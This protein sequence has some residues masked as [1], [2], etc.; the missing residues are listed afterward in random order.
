MLLTKLTRYVRTQSGN[1]RITVAFLVHM[2]QIA[3]Q[4]LVLRLFVKIVSLSFRSFLSLQLA[5]QWK[6]MLN[7]SF[8]QHMDAIKSCSTKQQCAIKVYLRNILHLYVFLDFLASICTSLLRFSTFHLVAQM[9]LFMLN[10]ITNSGE[11]HELY[12]ARVFTYLFSEFTINGKS[13]NVTTNNPVDT[14]KNVCKLF[15]YSLV[16]TPRPQ[17]QPFKLAT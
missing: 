5:G 1:A 8:T 16:Y 10:Q 9:R 13:P 14:K 6:N 12:Q 4:G 15:F 2:Y 3:A 11:K 17:R 7:E